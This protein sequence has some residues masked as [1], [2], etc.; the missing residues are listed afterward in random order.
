VNDHLAHD[1]DMPAKLRGLTTARVGLGRYGCGMPTAPLLEFQVAHARAR[2]AVHDALD[3]EYLCGRLHDLSPIMV[4]SRIRDRSEFLRRPDFGRQLSSEAASRLPSGSFDVAFVLADGLSA[5]ALQAHAEPLLRA[6][7]VQLISWRV[8]PVVVAQQAR[9]ALGDE[10]AT[11]LGAQSV[12]VLIG[13][14][15]GLAAADSLGVY[16]T[17]RPR[18]GIADSERNCISNIHG[19][20]MSHAEAAGRLVWLLENARARGYTGVALKDGYRAPSAIEATKKR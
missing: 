6:A 8:A 17:W 15:P 5:R 12:V 10:I 4:E 16:A 2:Q 9:V 19:R 7:L 3:G 18:Q 13:E 20:G 11:R 1:A 14:R